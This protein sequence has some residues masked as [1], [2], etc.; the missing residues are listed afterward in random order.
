MRVV[1]ESE[2][3]CAWI[4]LRNGTVQCS[5]DCRTVQYCAAV[6]LI[7]AVYCCEKSTFV[8]QYLAIYIIRRKET[9]QLHYY[10]GRIYGSKSPGKPSSS[11][12]VNHFFRD[13]FAKHA[14][15][16]PAICRLH[17][18]DPLLDAADCPTVRCHSPARQV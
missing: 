7:A 11:L 5:P 6:Q 15:M 16:H 8:Q 12:V 13:L 2:D 3:M 4:I 14:P 9:K 1:G 17:V 18:R 10:D